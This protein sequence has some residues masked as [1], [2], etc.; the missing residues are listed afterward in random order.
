MI[1]QPVRSL[2]SGGL[3]GTVGIRH[4]AVI[5]FAAALLVGFAAVHAQWSP[6]HRWNRAFGDASVVLVALSMA[7]GPLAR[8][9]RPA[10]RLLRFRRELGIYGFLLALVH[11]VIILVGWVQ[12]DL[13]R[14]FGFELHPDFQVYVMFQQGFGLAN[15]I[16]LAALFLAAILGLTSSDLA[17]RRLGPSGWKFLQMGVLPL[18]WLTVAHVAYFLFLHFMS[19]HRETPDPNPLQIW[20]VGLV[21][22]VLGLRAAAYLQTIRGKLGSSKI[23]GVAG[24]API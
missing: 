10:V 9:V 18:W 24:D 4:L 1:K 5:V 12:W 17:L 16:G 7:I 3:S 21:I 8:L 2:A 22:A 13:M 6:M 11:T 19:F 23:E 14:L 15:G 20:F